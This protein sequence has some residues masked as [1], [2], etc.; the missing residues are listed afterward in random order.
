VNNLALMKKLNSLGEY[1]G[2]IAEAVSDL[3]KEQRIIRRKQN[4]ILKAVNPASSGD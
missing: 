2:I 4:E 3:A 1:L